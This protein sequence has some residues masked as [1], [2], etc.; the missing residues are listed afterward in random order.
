M[1]FSRLTRKYASRMEETFL[2]NLRSREM[3]A[4]YL[5][6]KKPEYVSDLLDKDLHLADFTV[7]SEVEWAGSEL[8]ELNFGQR[9]GVHVVSILRGRKRINIPK[10]T[11]RI[12]PQD[13][14]QVIGSD[15]GIEN[16]GAALTRQADSLPED[17]AEGE[18]V[19]RR[20]PLEEGSPFS[21]KALKDSGL[22]NKHHC[23]VVGIEKP[24]GTLHAPSPTQPLEAGNTLWLVGEHKDLEALLS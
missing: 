9:Y 1:L 7:P 18:M 24:D 19:L 6:E 23:L 20:L 10:A 22:R 21:G 12:F 13:R 4:E 15:T 5:G 14:I 3:R 16:F 17:L 8:R 11:D 2:T